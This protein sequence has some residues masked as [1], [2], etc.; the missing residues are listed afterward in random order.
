[1]TYLGI[2]GSAGNPYSVQGSFTDSN[3]DGTF[4]DKG[5]INLDRS[6]YWIIV[7]QIGFDNGASQSDFASKWVINGAVQGQVVRMDTVRSATLQISMR[8]LLGVGSQ[9]K[10]QMWSGGG[11]YVSKHEFVGIFIPTPDYRQ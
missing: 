11:P 8:A 3:L 1:M 2:A 4:R 7:L 6:G 9:V 5:F 10:I